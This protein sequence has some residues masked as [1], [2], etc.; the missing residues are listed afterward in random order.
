MDFTQEELIAIIERT[1]R[2]N[3]FFT[4]FFPKRNTH[5]AEKL[6]VQIKKGKKK[7][8]PFVANR[9]GGKLLLR[10]GFETHNIT[11]PK[12]APTRILTV[13]DISKRILGEDI[14]SKKTPEQ[15]AMELFAKD[16]TDLEESIS[17]RVE[18][19]ARSILLGETIDITDEDSGVDIN[20]N[21]NF[22]NK[23]TL[24]GGA[25]W[26]EAS[27]D[28]IA[29]LKRW[30]KNVIKKSGISPK[31]CVMG[32]NAFNAFINNPKVKEMLNNLR[33]SLGEITPSIIDDAL[34]FQGKIIGLEIYTYDEWF[35][36]DNDVE[37]PMLPLD[38]VLLLPKEV[39]SIEYGCITIMEEDEQF[40]TY[41]SELVPIIYADRKNHAK[42]LT[43]VSRALTTPY[44]VDAWAV[45]VVV[46][47]EV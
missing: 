36:N 27:S 22:T 35:L 39:G 16:L 28:P 32:E 34:T 2:I 41:E 13:D 10:E 40:R 7:M 19:M 14:Y 4:N 46:D 8:A 45:L 6:E 37:Q 3:K 9:V 31:L 15:R 5:L 17:N 23:E 12:L 1:T 38:T 47:E 25:K 44:D 29:D 42:E 18:W 11:T 43:L 21:F 33:I 20:V 24:V 26:S 30:R